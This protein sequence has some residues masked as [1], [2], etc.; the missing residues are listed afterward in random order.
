MPRFSIVMSC[1]NPGPVIES[2][3]ASVLQQTYDDVEAIIVD[4]GSSDD[5][6]AWIIDFMETRYQAGGVDAGS[7][8]TMSCRAALTFQLAHSGKVVRLLSEPDAG[9]YDAL[10]KGVRR[11]R[12]D[13]VG[14]VHADDRLAHPGVLQNVAACFDE[15]GADAV[16][17][18]LQYVRPRAGGDAAVFRHWR[19]GGYDRQKLAWGWMPPHPALYLK[20]SVYER[21]SLAPG[22]FFDPGFR[23]AADYDFILRLFGRHGVVPAYLPEVLV[24]MRTGGVSNRSLRHLMRK[25]VEDWKAI[26]RNQAGHL[27]TLIGKNLR[28]IGQFRNL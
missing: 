10:N 17:G 26:R 21:A 19:S 27:H 24:H 6:V 13:F 1:L 15:T 9:L 7:Q 8:A 22:V 12:G 28:K 11:A 4:G 23:C 16:Y 2:A 18:D 3:L 5:T 20:Q 25:S 14:F